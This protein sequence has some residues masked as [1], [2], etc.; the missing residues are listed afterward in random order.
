MGKVVGPLSAVS[1]FHGRTGA[2]GV[3]HASRDDR[4]GF[5]ELKPGEMRAE[6]IVHATAE[7][8]HHRSA[9]A[10]DVEV[11]RIVVDGGIA[12]GRAGVGDEQSARWNHYSGEFD[13]L[14]GRAEGPERDR[15]M[16]H[17][18]LNGP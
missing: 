10:C 16:A 6:A 15:R 2:P 3:G 7:G 11:V 17:R 13:V 5:G 18:L 1:G 12:V 8:L 14:D 4:Q 9:V